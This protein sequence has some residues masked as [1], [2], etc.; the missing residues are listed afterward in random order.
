MLDFSFDVDIINDPII[1][2]IMRKRDFRSINFPACDWSA[3]TFPAL[4]LVDSGI[5]LMSDEE[6]TPSPV[7]YCLIYYID[8]NPNLWPALKLSTIDV[9]Q[10]YLF[11]VLQA[12]TPNY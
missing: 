10:K 1:I 11:V 3:D 4:S 12:S 6:L 8:I 9:Y 7:L 2:I 5:R